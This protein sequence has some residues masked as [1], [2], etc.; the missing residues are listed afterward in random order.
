MVSD[1]V[2]SRDRVFRLSEVMNS[3]MLFFPRKIL[4]AI[5]NAGERDIV[6][7]PTGEV[8]EFDA[9]THEIRGGVFAEA[10]VDF[11]PDRGARKFPGVDYRGN[12]VVVR[13][14]ARGADPRINNVA[15]ISTGTPPQTCDRGNDCNQCKV[16]SKELWDQSGA[17]RFKFSTDAEFER[18]LIARCGFG[19]PQ[20]GADIAVSAA[21]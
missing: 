2:P 18:F 10:A 15:T 7:L 19:L 4:P 17:E 20:I 3:L 6:T 13:V 14:N 16:P 1:W 12:G 9:A 11:N 5:V 8:V 21:P